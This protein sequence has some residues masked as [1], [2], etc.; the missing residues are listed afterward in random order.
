VS[1]GELDL[2]VLPDGL[3]SESLARYPQVG[4]LI[5]GQAHPVPVLPFA[6]FLRLLERQVSLDG[7]AHGRGV[8]TGR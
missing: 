5:T 4:A 7:L 1:P 2:L 8:L 6:Q 3:T